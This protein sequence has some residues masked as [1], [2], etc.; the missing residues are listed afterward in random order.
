MTARDKP[1]AILGATSRLARDFVLAE[2]ARGQ[3]DVRFALYARRPEAAAAFVAACAL[4][5]DWAIGAL[6]DF[7]ETTETARTAP[8]S[9]VVN[10]V[11]V[12]D[13][14]RAAAMGAQ[15]FT[16]THDG[17]TLAMHHVRKFP[18]TPYVF[19]SSGA[20]Y[21]SD[22]AAPA[23]ATTA[24]RLPINAITPEHFYAAAKLYT[25]VRHRA[26]AGLTLVDVRIFNVVSRRMDPASRFIV[27]D[28][29]R[30]VR[31]ATV[32]E[33]VDAPMMRDYLGPEDLRAL[34][35]AALSA[36]VGFNGAIDA[37]SRAPISKRELVELF[38]SEFGMKAAWREPADVINAT[39]AKPF[40]YSE[41][42]AAAVLGFQPRATSAEAVLA[43]MAAFL[44]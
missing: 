13:P 35:Q 21:G 37:Y 2:H 18:A 28:M 10:F 11:G 14:A 16:A 40:Y 33:T 20:V 12:G 9:G 39:G 34:L 41:N 42:R 31:E 19:M 27:S 26:E 4:P 38:V 44:R 6:P 23:T 29:A 25:E 24:A 1:L 36:P 15:I 7:A 17:D 32:F 30:A 43:E 22:F 8:F 3:G 5:G